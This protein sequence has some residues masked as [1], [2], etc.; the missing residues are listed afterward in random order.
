MLVRRAVIAVGL[1]A[2]LAGAGAG[3]AAAETETPTPGDKSSGLLDSVERTLS[4]LT[5]GSTDGSSSEQAPRRPGDNGSGGSGGKEPGDSGGKDSGKSGAAHTQSTDSAAA[6][7]VGESSGDSGGDSAGS[8]P[9]GNLPS[10]PEPGEGPLLDQQGLCA[11]GSLQGKA[12]SC[13]SDTLGNGY[14]QACIREDGGVVSQVGEAT[15]LPE[16]AGLDCPTTEKM[17]PPSGGDDE[18]PRD[19]T[20]PT[21]MPPPL[22]RA[23]PAKPAEPIVAE[24]SFTG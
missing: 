9:L 16:Q 19:D 18:E 7:Q 23:Q 4:S 5:G 20:E 21:P 13:E 17:P 24:P 3:T 10:L 12:D 14:L 2:A 11:D 22:N 1:S 6:N 15:G 8:D